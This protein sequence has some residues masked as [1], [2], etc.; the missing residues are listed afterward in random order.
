MEEERKTINIERNDKEEDPP[1]FFE[2]I[3]LEEEMEEDIMP[4]PAPAKWPKYVP[5]QK[6]RV[7]VP[8]DLDVVKDTLITLTLPKGVLF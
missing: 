5:P 7:K 4:V 3:E 1:T 8:K 6:G 2:E